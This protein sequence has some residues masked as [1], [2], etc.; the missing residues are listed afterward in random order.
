MSFGKEKIVKTFNYCDLEKDVAIEPG[1]ILIN[2]YIAL[3]WDSEKYILDPRKVKTTL[4]IYSTLYDEIFE[5]YPNE[6]SVGMLMVNS[7]PSVDD[8]VPEGK[9]ILLDGWIEEDSCH[10]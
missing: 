6:S 2:F 10:E 7:G 5:M 4:V 3:G 9:I 8:N 1:D